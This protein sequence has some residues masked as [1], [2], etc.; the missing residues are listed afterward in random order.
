[1]S[2]DIMDHKV[3]GAGGTSFLLRNRRPRAVGAGAGTAPVLFVH[4][5]TYPSSVMF[6]YPVDGVSWMSW[7][8]GA[9]FDVWCIDLPGYGGA[10]RPA[11]MAAEPGA[12]DPLMDT[13]SAASEVKQAIAFILEHS[14]AA[15]LDLLGYSWGSAICGQVAGESPDRVRRLVLAGPLWLMDGATAAVPPG[16]LGAYRRV[17]AEAIVRRWTMGLDEHQ[18]GAVAPPER[19][20]RW[21]AAAVASDPDAASVDPP[22]L[23]APSGVIKDVRDFWLAGSPSYD[24]GRVRCPTLVVVG[25]WDRETTPAQGAALF[26]A[27]TAAAERRYTVIGGGTHSLL[28]ENQRHQLYAVVRDFLQEQSHAGP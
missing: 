12:G 2:I 4:G 28:L 21:A 3:P 5:A 9:G 6:D 27:L 16:P 7:M 24:P 25:E 20:Q 10:D 14:G 26:G 13:R 8:A 22:Q 23:R 15:R 18:K 11:A 17:G 19:I 1:M